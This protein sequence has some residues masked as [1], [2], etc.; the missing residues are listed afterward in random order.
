MSLVRLLISVA[1]LA[2]A[3]LLPGVV[4]AHSDLE[5][6]SPEAG[7]T[8]DEPP[9]EVAMVFS[10]E[11]E[12]DGSGFVVTDADGTEVGAGEVDL[13][14]AER[15]ELRGAVEI[16]EPGV[17]TVSW[18]AIAADGDEQTG[19]FTFAY[20]TDA[21]AAGQDAPDTALQSPSASVPTILAGMLLLLAIV[22][23]ALQ[24]GRARGS[25]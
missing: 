7:A 25:R 12:A 5:S 22:L 16:T 2:T 17:Y 19:D 18:T 10:G 24:L 3:A 1:M 23:A 20:E 21:G 13:D 9:T 15:N 11:L 6:T 8:L 4:A 14:V